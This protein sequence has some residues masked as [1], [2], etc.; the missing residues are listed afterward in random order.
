M[1]IDTIIHSIQLGNYSDQT[2]E[3]LSDK[4]K[5]I[6]LESKK[7]TIEKLKERI[8]C[9]DSEEKNRTLEALIRKLEQ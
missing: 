6:N 9:F 3:S 4:I 1:D 2:V 7:S 8:G 5:A